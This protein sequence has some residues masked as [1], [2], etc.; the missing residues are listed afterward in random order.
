MPQPTPIKPRTV[1]L[2]SPL[3]HAR[4][5]EE[6]GMSPLST[7][8]A[9]EKMDSCSGQV[10][11]GGGAVW[12]SAGRTR[13]TPITI[14][15][16]SAPH[17][18]P[19]PTT[20]T[21]SSAHESAP[22]PPPPL[23]LGAVQHEEPGLGRPQRLLPLEHRTRQAQGRMHAPRASPLQR[24][25]WAPRARLPTRPH[26]RLGGRTATNGGLL[27]TLRA[28]VPVC[29][30]P[31]VGRG[32]GRGRSTRGL[33]IPTVPAVLGTPTVPGM[34]PVPTVLGIPPVPPSG[35]A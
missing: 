31:V 10:G 11:R 3:T 5:V 13:S 22:A 9:R 18:Y 30:I 14:V 4:D 12:P 21:L 32:C 23:Y 2:T 1:Q 34:P 27:L 35:G 33:R 16:T 19:T 8:P 7:P 20:L 6:I 28:A 24:G 26:H 17:R 25:W 29:S 15:P